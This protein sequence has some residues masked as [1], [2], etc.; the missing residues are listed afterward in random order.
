M[1]P[2]THFWATLA[3]GITTT[4]FDF[5]SLLQAVAILFGGVLIDTDHYLLYAMKKNDLSL[6]RAYKWFYAMYLRREKR[7]FLYIF[8]AIESFIVVFA[9]GFIHSIFFYIFA[10]MVFH[11]I[12]DIIQAAQHKHY[13]KYISIIYYLTKNGLK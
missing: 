4:F 5:T 10:G 8:H 13:A 7:R 6:R 1:L 9:L 2:K 3:L 11:L 12:L